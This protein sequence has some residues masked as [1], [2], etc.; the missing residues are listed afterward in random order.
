VE[1]NQ[2]MGRLV[3]PS[4]TRRPLRRRR[5]WYRGWPCALPTSASG[6]RRRAAAGCL[7]W[8]VQQETTL[9]AALNL[10]VPPDVVDRVT[11]FPSEVLSLMTNRP[12]HW[13]LQSIKGW[14]GSD[15]FEQF[16]C[17]LQV[18]FNVTATHAARAY[19]NPCR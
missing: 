2:V 13:R 10:P 3:P 18:P 6:S 7:L 17:V 1:V 14:I 15:L 4:V 5:V 9:M 16:F 11:E 19:S 8:T 12:A